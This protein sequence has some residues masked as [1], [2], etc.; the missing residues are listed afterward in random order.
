MYCN[1]IYYDIIKTLGKEAKFVFIVSQL[2]LLKETDKPKTAKICL[3]GI[4][5]DIKVSS[6][7]KCSRCWQRTNDINID[8]YQGICSRC[9]LN[10]YGKGET[11]SIL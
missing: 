5:V 6:L 1:K 4:F 2:Y 3:D 9:I 10:I 7:N 8:I 11:R